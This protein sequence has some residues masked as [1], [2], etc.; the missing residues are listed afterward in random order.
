MTFVALAVPA[1]GV[2]GYLFYR[3]VGRRPDRE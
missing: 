1:I 3:K 2:L